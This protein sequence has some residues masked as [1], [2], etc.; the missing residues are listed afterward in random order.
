MGRRVGR[1][2]GRSSGR[3]AD[4]VPRRHGARTASSTSTARRSTCRHCRASRSA[5]AAWPGRRRAARAARGAASRS[6]RGPRRTSASS[7]AARARIPSSSA[8]R[9]V[10]SGRRA[11]RSRGPAGVVSFP[12][13]RATK[14][15]G[16]RVGDQHRPRPG[17]ATGSGRFPRP[18][19]RGACPR[20]SVP[21]VL[22]PRASTSRSPITIAG[23]DPADRS[24]GVVDAETTIFEPGEEPGRRTDRSRAR[25]PARDCGRLGPQA[26]ALLDHAARRRSTT[27]ARPRCASRAGRSSIICGDGGCIERIVT[28]YG[29]QAPEPDRRPLPAGLLQ[30]LRLPLVERRDEGHGS[31]LL[32]LTER[33]SRRR[34]PRYPLT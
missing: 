19:R 8:D 10:P 1:R 16:R 6:P 2:C 18:Q 30:D 17:I 26:A 32:T 7:R 27:T 28:D 24:G 15:V 22:D 4:A 12:P 33:R 29:P 3:P 5:T 11:L 9:A 21:A 31:R 25:R 23:L 14:M 20:R 13:Y 34:A